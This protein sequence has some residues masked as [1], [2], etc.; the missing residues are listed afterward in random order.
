MDSDNLSTSL[1]HATLFCTRNSLGKDRV[2]ALEGS[3]QHWDNSADGQKLACSCFTSS[4]SQDWT[5]RSVLGDEPC[6]CAS[7]CQ[8]NDQR[9]AC[10]DGGLDCRGA[11]GLDWAHWALRK[12]IGSDGIVEALVVE[13]A[14][15]LLTNAAHCHDRTLWE[16]AVGSLTGQ[17]NHVRAIQH[18][19]QD[20][21]SLC[22][23]WPR[24]SF[25]RVEHLSGRHNELASNVA[26]GNDHLLHK[27]NLF[28]VYF[29]AHVT[30][31]HHDAVASLDD[32]IDVVDALLI[33]NL[34]DDLDGTSPHAKGV[35]D[36]LHIVCILHEGGGNE[37]DTL[38][39]AKLN[40]I[41]LVLLLQHRELHLNTWQIHVLLLANRDVVQ[42]LSHDKVR[43]TALDL[44]R[45]GAICSQ[46]DLTW[47]HRCWKSLVSDG[48]AGLVTL[49]RIV[50]HQ[51]QVL[52]LL[53]IDLSASQALFEEAGADLRSLGVQQDGHMLVRSQL[54][55]LTDACHGLTMG[56]VVAVGKIQAADVETLVDELHQHVDIPAARAHG[57]DDLALA[58]EAVFGVLLQ[59]YH[60]GPGGGVIQ[61]HWA[62]L[63]HGCHF[64]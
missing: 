38:R 6:G 29:H 13:H 22:T 56:L 64:G 3:R 23:C 43:S 10:I 18:S 58:V 55:C 52:P 26:L 42:H 12:D 17:H 48:K 63:V 46:D 7:L 49:E 20:I 31:G 54:G 36:D 25:H 40:E 28:N 37:V 24:S 59:G 33:L 9:A 62:L 2:S 21:R 41:L 16:L 45:Q 30:T 47:L 14:L 35:A 4:D 50:R 15:S 61:E 1:H 32:L 19:I 11:D 34:G 60:G 51:L 57:A 44:Q 27:T 39:N 5:L 53:Q 8:G